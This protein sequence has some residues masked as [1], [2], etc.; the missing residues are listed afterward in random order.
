MFCPAEREQVPIRFYLP[1]PKCVPL[2]VLLQG[3][4]KCCIERYRA[5]LFGTLYLPKDKTPA[6]YGINDATPSSLF[7]Q[8]AQPF[9]IGQ[10][11]APPPPPSGTSKVP[12]NFNHVEAEDGLAYFNHG[13]GG[14][15]GDQAEKVVGQ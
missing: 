1:E 13:S 14:D 3:L 8:L 5:A 7:G 12:V 2:R 15:N 10:P 9:M 4:K 6:R 11:D